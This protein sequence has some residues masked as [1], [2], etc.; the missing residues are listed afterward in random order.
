MTEN[1]N[2]FECTDAILFFGT[3]FRG[4]HDW[5]QHSLPELAK[6]V[7]PYVEEGTFETFKKGSVTLYELRKAFN[8]KCRSYEQPSFCCFWEAERSNVGKII[9][10]DTI[11]RVSIRLIMLL[12][13]HTKLNIRSYWSI[14]S[15]LN[16]WKVHL[17][18]PGAFSTILVHW[19]G[20]ILTCTILV[21][22]TV[23]SKLWRFC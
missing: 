21:K 8:T 2:L 7:T 19:S 11:P 14:Q 20:T 10:D 9:G 12:Q 18:G 17:H 23:S 22:M 15:L 5:F 6:E 13:Q 4:I 1:I 16:S 3:P